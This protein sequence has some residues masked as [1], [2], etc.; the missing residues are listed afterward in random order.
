MA[1]F[2][3]AQG[4][5][6]GRRVASRMETDGSDWLLECRVWHQDECSRSAVRRNSMLRCSRASVSSS[7]L[8]AVINSKRRSPSN[9][10]RR[11]S[12]SARWTTAPAAAARIRRLARMKTSVWNAATSSR[13]W[14]RR[15]LRKSRWRRTRFAGAAGGSWCSAPNAATSAVWSRRQPIGLYAC[16]SK[17]GD[18][19]DG[20]GTRACAF[21]A[22]LVLALAF[23]NADRMRR[24]RPR[25]MLRNRQPARRALRC[26]ATMNR[27]GPGD[28]FRSPQPLANLEARPIGRRC[29]RACRR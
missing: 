10:R 24:Q 7:V 23:A 13:W 16:R 27:C 6:E 11:S 26:A 15:S 5:K 28:T 20:F 2:A 22:G 29:L 1:T 9:G 17:T 4:R 18:G 12:A 21:G 25:T 14:T 19:G 8:G 3:K